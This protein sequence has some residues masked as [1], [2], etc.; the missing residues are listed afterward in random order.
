M[1]RVREFEMLERERLREREGGGEE[2]VGKNNK[3]PLKTL[4]RNRNDGKILS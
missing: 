3:N 1:S 4:S 2:R